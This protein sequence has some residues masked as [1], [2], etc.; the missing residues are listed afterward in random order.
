MPKRA[1]NITESTTILIKKNLFVAVVY[2]AAAILF[3]KNAN[4]QVHSI[5][6]IAETPKN[7]PII[8]ENN[9]IKIQQK[10]FSL[11]WSSNN[12][13]FT[14]YR[15]RLIPYSQEWSQ[16]SERNSAAFFELKEGSYLFLLELPNGQ[17]KE[18]SI[19]VDLPI[20]NH[21]LFYIGSIVLLSFLAF[22]TIILLFRQRIRIITQNIEEEFKKAFNIKQ[23]AREKTTGVN[24][25][26]VKAQA[27]I[28]S[29]KYKKVTVLFADIQGFT[30]IVEH[31]NPE[32]LIDELDRFFFYFDGVVDKYNIEKI[33]TIGD[34]YMCAGGIPS[35]NRT[36]PVEVTLAALEMQKFMIDSKVQ[37]NSEFGF[38]ELRIGLHTGPVISGE[39]GRKNVSFDIWG[40]TV[41]IASRMESS[42]TAGMV[43]ITGV[44]FELIKDFFDCD[45]RGKMPIK[46][47]GETDMYFVKRIKKELS[48]D[49]DGIFPN[50]KFEIKL[51]HIRFGDLEEFILHKLD[52]ELTEGLFYHNKAHTQD[53]LTRIEILARGEKVTSED[54]LVLKTAAL[55][56]DIGF[57]VEYKN[58]EDN[59]ISFAKEV[60]P[61]YHY[62]DYQI[63]QVVELIN[64]T[65]VAKKPRNYLE[66]ILKDADLDYLGRADF[67]SI[68]D[69]LFK[70]LNFHNGK[71][72]IEEWNKLQFDFI[73]EHT[74]YTS[75]ARQLRQV[76]KE[77]QLQKLKV[78]IKE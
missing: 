76:N 50:K 46:Y 71:M 29:R 5:E 11:H 10:S 31:I 39:I 42:G 52:T 40:D 30:K 68:S 17:I 9:F 61:Q 67:I 4:A 19:Q 35:I 57:I 55:L 72:T 37:Q 6:I 22:A 18:A 21:T 3:A 65:R 25:K 16:W 74:Y 60:L 20:W 73:S 34:A 12:S 48:Q 2:V 63:D 38:W 13:S 69:N 14:K 49:E 51:Q 56:H 53:V 43:N 7:E 1:V 26:T 77:R 33:K 8:V 62:H 28:R 64:V 47:K 36:N 59:S 15:Y 75:T 23:K 44:T 58:H 32:T 24:A 78:L 45:Y 54:L 70:E 27:R 41:N 66:K